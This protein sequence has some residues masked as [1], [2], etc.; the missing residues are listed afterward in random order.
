MF[1]RAI[2]F[3]T[4][5][6]LMMGFTPAHAQ[7]AYFKR[8]Q[9]GSGPT[10][11]IP[12]HW[13]VVDSASVQNRALAGQAIADKAGVGPADY[14][15]SHQLI[16]EATPRPPAAQIRASIVAQTELSQ[17]ALKAASATDLLEI[18]REFSE[19]MKKMSA[20]GPVKVRTMDRARVESIN[21]QLALVLSYTRV[22]E[23]NPDLWRVEQIKIPFGDQYLSFTLSYR[24]D[25][26]TLMAPILDRVKRSVRF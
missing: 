20:N 14:I 13:T 8:V 3:V 19:G 24:V 9:I 15:K 25:S 18:E 23:P 7:T 4:L 26:Q 16:V 17:A 10:I 6:V 11:E 5:M 12:S 1:L 21:R 22:T 2:G